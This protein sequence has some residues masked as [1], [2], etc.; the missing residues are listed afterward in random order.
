MIK[1]RIVET[2]IDDKGESYIFSDTKMSGWDLGGHTITDMFFSDTCPPDMLLESQ[3][4][5]DKNFNLSDIPP[6]KPLY[7]AL[8][9]NEKP[10]NFR[11]LFYHSTTTVDYIMVSRGE[12]VMVIGNQDVLLKAG[13]VVIQRGAAHAW[14]NYTNEMATIMG[15]MIGVELPKQF[16]RVD[17]IQPEN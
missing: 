4:M 11:D 10:K 3:E 14:H 1:T 16:H 9:E 5:Q 12:L 2:A 6:T 17:T 13:E 8:P 15:I 7:D